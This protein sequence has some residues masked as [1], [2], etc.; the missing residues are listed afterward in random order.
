[1]PTPWFSVAT[2]FKGITEVHGLLGN[3]KILEMFRISGHPEVK[4]DETPWCAAFVG[5]CLRLA[6]YRSSG[7]LGARS[8]EGFGDDLKEEPK[9]GCIVVFWRESRKSQTTRSRSTTAS[10]IA[11]SM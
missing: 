8:Y 5:S 6:G 4:E 10:A 7:S 2:H 3:P 11:N 9:R 1:M